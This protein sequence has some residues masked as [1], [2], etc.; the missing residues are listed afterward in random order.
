MEMATG[1]AS[2]DLG[3]PV[4]RI[5]DIPITKHVP[6]DCTLCVMNEWAR[7]YAV[8][9]SGLSEN[10]IVIT[11]QPVFEGDMTVDKSKLDAVKEKLS[12]DKYR[13]IVTF[14]TENGLNQD[15]DLSALYT[16]A[17]DMS[18]T[19][20]IVKL[21]PNQSFDD[22]LHTSLKNVV[23]SKDDAQYFLHFSD[24]AITTFS[25]T[26]MEAAMM[27]IPVISVNFYDRNYIMDYGKMRIAKT[28]VNQQE[29][30]LLIKELLN[31]DSDEYKALKVSRKSFSYTANAASN[32]ADLVLNF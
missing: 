11:G 17:R 25:T 18:D 16:V 31:P 15:A 28:A 20:F 6:H 32:I 29:L 24:L 12:I 2:A 21:H 27:D 10:K 4:I 13:K 22:I 14:F 23:L 7:D 19:M 5:N 26:G 8:N 1:I 3:I 9:H 30:R